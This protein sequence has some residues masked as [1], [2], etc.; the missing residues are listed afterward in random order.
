MNYQGFIIRFVLGTGLLL[1]ATLAVNWLFDPLWYFGGNKVG[2]HNYAFNER[3]SKL[4]LVESTTFDCLVLGS[5]RAT[6]IRPSLLDKAECFNMAFSGGL[7]EE[8]SPYVR[9]LKEQGLN[10][11]DHLIVGVDG[12]N[13][14][15]A[16]DAVDIQPVAVAEPPPS[17]FE[18]YLSISA[19]DF[20]LRL[21]LGDANLPRVYNDKFEVEVLD[22]LPVFSPTESLQGAILGT[23]VPHKFA[24][25]QE[26]VEIAQ[27]K[28]VFFFV[29]P[30]S[31]WHIKDLAE[32]GILTDYVNAL[33]Q[34][35]EAGY[36]LLDYSII[37]PVTKDPA[38]T[39]DGHHYLPKINETIA[40]HLNSLLADDKP[41]LDGFGVLVND[42]SVQ[43]YS[44]LYQQRLQEFKA[45]SLTVSN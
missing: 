25:Y 17:I 8:F 19:L 37:S 35:V 24:L 39:Y 13:F 42:L 7:V 9:R 30:L 6:F 15:K 4:N 32:K 36:V 41:V 16:P 3:V 11:L 34:F 21:Y 45:Q 33:Y 27:P 43:Q 38:N 12:T 1:G 26:L 29:P 23:F 20:S 44:E 31:A 28:Q 40:A 14:F 22:Q 18:S 5:S 10:N 2:E